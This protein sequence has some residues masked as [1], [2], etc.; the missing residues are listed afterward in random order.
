MSWAADRLSEFLQLCQSGQA[1]IFVS[2]RANKIFSVLLLT[3]E[4]TTL[5]TSRELWRIVTR[6]DG[7]MDINI[8]VSFSSPDSVVHEDFKEMY[9][10]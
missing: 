5:R 10:Y 6:V 4:Q 3:I 7:L 1:P 9:S 2:L 8:I